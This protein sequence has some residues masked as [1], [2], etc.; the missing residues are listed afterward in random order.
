MTEAVAAATFP[1]RFSRVALKTVARNFWALLTGEALARIIGIAIA[2]RLARVLGV[3]GFGTLEV[4]LAV[5]VYLQLFVDGGLDLVATRAVA[6]RPELRDQY[7]GNLIGLRLATAAM[8]VSAVL[9]INALTAQTPLLDGVVFRYALSVVPAACA[10]GWAFQASE[11][12]R[13]VAA[14]NVITQLVY[15]AG[16][17]YAV[18]DGHGTLRVPIAYTAASA[19]GAVAVGLWYVRRYG[20]IYPRFDPGFWR[21]AMAQGLPVAGARGLRAVSYN[22]DVLMLGYLFTHAPVGLYAAAYRIVTLPLLGYATLFTALFPAVVR[23]DPGE[24]ARFVAIGMAAIGASALT[25]AIVLWSTA[26]ALLTFLMGAAFTGGASALRLLA[27]SIPLTAAGGVCRQ[28]LLA[29]GHQ[30]VDLVVVA[31]GAVANVILNILLIP[32]FGLVGAATATVTAEG[33]VLV[34]ALTGFLVMQSRPAVV[35]ATPDLRPDPSV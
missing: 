14:G 10:L 29:S 26:A 8:A 25:I 35:V 17:W 28:V 24:R 20:W 4:G 1:A 11:R 13:A 3:D 27:W 32:S 30:R 9:V 21:T 5:L 2:L 33:I 12:M 15:L 7:A 34:G 31:C 23:L 19:A 22:F 18:H 16:V 6:R